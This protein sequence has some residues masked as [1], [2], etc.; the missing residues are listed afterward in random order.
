MD[1]REGREDVMSPEGG[2]SGQGD[3]STR[4]RTQGVRKSLFVYKREMREST[5]RE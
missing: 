4:G 5:V 2:V 1:G 3:E